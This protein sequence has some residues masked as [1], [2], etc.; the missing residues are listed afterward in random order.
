MM[1]PHPPFGVGDDAW[2]AWVDLELPYLGDAFDAPRELR[3]VARIPDR[4]IAAVAAEQ[5]FRQQERDRKQRSVQ[6][7]AS[8]SQFEN[9]RDNLNLDSAMGGYEQKEMFG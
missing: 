1:S 4:R 7:R 5:Y 8:A 9:E 3:L 6:C 2:Q